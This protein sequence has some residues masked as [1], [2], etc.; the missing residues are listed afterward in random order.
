MMEPTHHPFHHLF[1]Q[2]GLEASDEAI[3][4]F[5]ATHQLPANVELI[6]APFWSEAQANFLE[7]GLQEDSDWAEVIDQ[8]NTSLR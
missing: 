1:E 7:E 8:L 2:L 4:D 3:K 5:I 6:E